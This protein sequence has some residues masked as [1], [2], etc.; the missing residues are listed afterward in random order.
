MD[1]RDALALEQQRHPG[2][3]RFIGAGAV[4]H[5]LAGSEHLRLHRVDGVGGQPAAPRND[6]RRGRDVEWGPEIDDRDVFSGVEAP[7]ERLG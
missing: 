5:H 7:L 6:V 4:E 2:T 1:P 3:R